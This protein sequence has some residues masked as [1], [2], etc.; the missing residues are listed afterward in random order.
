MRL[1]RF[2]VAIRSLPNI[3]SG[4][5]RGSELQRHISRIG[6]ELPVQSL[7]ALYPPYANSRWNKYL[8][9][10]KHLRRNVLICHKTELIGA[11]PHRVLDIGCGGGIFLYCAQ[12]FGHTG[13]G[14]D[15]DDPLFDKM[16][17]ALRIDRRIERV[18]PFQPL[19]VAGPFDLITCIS[20]TFDR[21][22]NGENERWG[23]AEWGFLISDL[24]ERLAPAGRVFLRI[25][26]GDNARRD[27]TYYYDATIHQ[28]FLQGYIGRNEYLL[29]RNKLAIAI[30]RLGEARKTR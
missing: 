6:D 26:R 1:R 7:E 10:R 21:Y 16:A 28:A 4:N 5:K 19:A 20:P 27:G 30:A 15:I 23:P 24:A 2:L 14:I 12:Y 22:G 8:D 17:K 25:N 29:H 18:V 13:V 3:F 11:P 9:V